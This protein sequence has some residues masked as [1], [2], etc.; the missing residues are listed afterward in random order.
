M[1][2]RGRSPGWMKKPSAQRWLFLWLRECSPGF[3]LLIRPHGKSSLPDSADREW[4][5][6]DKSG[7]GFS[8]IVEY[9]SQPG[10]DGRW[11]LAVLASDA[12]W[13]LLV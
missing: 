1:A 9:T 11:S 7:E 4:H 2:R 12:S 8:P 5:S 10:R 3:K 6:T 13:L